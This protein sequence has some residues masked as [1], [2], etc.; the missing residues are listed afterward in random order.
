[1]KNHTRKLIKIRDTLEDINGVLTLVGVAVTA[2]PLSHDESNGIATVL[3]WTDSKLC[4]C[5]QELGNVI[6]K[7]SHLPDF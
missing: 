1:M 6:D 4:E 5:S 3:R 2:K 7:T